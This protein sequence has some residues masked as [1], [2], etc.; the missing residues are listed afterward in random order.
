[1]TRPTGY[2]ELRL[3]VLDKHVSIGLRLLSWRR[4]HKV[5]NDNSAFGQLGPVTYG[6]A[7]YV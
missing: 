1:M 7:L 3:A 5:N 2:I 6:W 4:Y